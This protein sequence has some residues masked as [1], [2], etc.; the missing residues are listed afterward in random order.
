MSNP[1]Y[2][3]VVARYNESVNW[4]DAF[5]NYTIYNKGRDDL[6][7]RHRAHSVRLPNVG[8]EAHS[9]VH[10]IVENY[11]RLEDVIIFSQGGYRAH[12][13]F[14][15]DEFL[16]RAL[17]LG[18]LGFSTKLGDIN[19]LVGSNSRDFVLRWH[20]VDL[21]TKDPYELGS[22]WE[23]TT[24]EP[25]V[26]SRSVFWG[27][28]FSVRRDFILRRSRDSYQRILKS[29]DWCTNPM[30]A[31]FC[32]R[33]W[34]NILNLPL[35]YI[36]PGNECRLPAHVVPPPERP[37]EFGLEDLVERWESALRPKGSSKIAVRFGAETP[38]PVEKEIVTRE[39]LVG[40]LDK[41]G[42]LM[43]QDEDT[44]RKVT[45]ALRDNIEGWTRF[46]CKKYPFDKPFASKPDLDKKDD[47]YVDSTLGESMEVGTTGS[48]TGLSFRYMRW[49]PAFHKIEWDYHYNLVMDEFEIQQSPNVLYFFSDHYKTDGVEPIACFGRPSDLAMNN[50]G[51]NRSPVVHYANF[52]VYQNDNEAFWRYLFEYV[53]RHHIDVFFTSAPQISSMCNYIRKFGV[54]HKI[55]YLLS[56]T[57]DRIM[58]ADAHFLFVENKYFDHICDHMR[59]WDGGATFFTCKH[60]NYHLM[61]N[62]CWVEEID[63][64]MICTE[65]FNLASPFVKYWNGDY[66]KIGKEYKRCE[67]GRLYREFEFVES[68]PF[69]LKGVCMKD[70]KDGLKALDISGIREVR[71]S[72]KYLDV[73]SLRPLEDEEKTKIS[74]LTDKFTFRFITEEFHS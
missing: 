21:H 38:K 57:G 2:R 62:L 4:V 44:V 31:H 58:P 71:C 72:V 63:G 48:T 26:R 33:A 12:A 61:D 7:A 39:E 18:D 32:E 27:A 17:D 5:V 60:R 30:E 9:Y 15:P 29:L 24:G 53:Q 11:D 19:G 25:W 65:Y 56:N 68:R 45:R 42:D 55:G 1:S 22:W 16:R 70:I 28:T 40:V 36:K 14:E 20:G 66:C 74:A 3:L 23:R 49:H 34:F 43:F 50:H 73:V 37:M 67:C 69:S 13:N 10:H 35:N 51:S 41:V 46:R 8:R 54:S 59:C 47:W 52:A 6:A 64:K